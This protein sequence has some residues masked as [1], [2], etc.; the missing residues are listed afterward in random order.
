MP[1]LIYLLCPALFILKALKIKYIQRVYHITLW[2]TNV[3]HMLHNFDQAK[4][5]RAYHH[6]LPNRVLFRV[7]KEE[8]T[9]I[10]NQ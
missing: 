10:K 3:L 1:P 8:Y 4:G 5:T 7:S 9:M 2:G 6:P